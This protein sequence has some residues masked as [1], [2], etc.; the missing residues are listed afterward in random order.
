M[1]LYFKCISLGELLH[2]LMNKT[3]NLIHLP[4]NVFYYPMVEQPCSGSN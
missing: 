1:Y 4:V 3:L 2:K